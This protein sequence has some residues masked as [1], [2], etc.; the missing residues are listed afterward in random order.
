MVTLDSFMFSDENP[1][2]R[3]VL[4]NS[5]QFL[6]LYDKFVYMYLKIHSTDVT[7]M[8]R[9]LSIESPR[10]KQMFICSTLDH[11]GTSF[12]DSGWGCGYRYYK[13]LKSLKIT[14]H[15]HKKIQ[16]KCLVFGCFIIQ[17]HELVLFLC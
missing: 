6:N 3:I 10:V 17:E 11:Y 4:D 1:K 2:I 5:K 7:T 13:Y 14:H 9:G 15:Y 8:I 16:L 12:G